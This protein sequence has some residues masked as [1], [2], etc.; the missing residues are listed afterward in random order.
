MAST[1][2]SQSS[3]EQSSISSAQ[4]SPLDSQQHSV[5]NEIS[6]DL[7]ASL[8]RIGLADDICDEFAASLRRVDRVPTPGSP[9]PQQQSSNSSQQFLPTT[10]SG[11]SAAVLI[12]V[13]MELMWLE[14]QM[15][16]VELTIVN[17]RYLGHGAFSGSDDG[18]KP[19]KSVVNDTQQLEHGAILSNRP[20]PW[21]NTGGPNIPGDGS[22]SLTE[23]DDRYK[24]NEH[25]SELL[26]GSAPETLSPTGKLISNGKFGAIGDGRPQRVR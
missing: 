22:F 8:R 25:Y 11:E 10:P 16:I 24:P 19:P 1:S 9:G 7:A 4:P 13:D 20:S 12:R 17:T 6:P 18:A 26:A 23:S 14:E 2:G 15:S 5:L 21:A 3:Q